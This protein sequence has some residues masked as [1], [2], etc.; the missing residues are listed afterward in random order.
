M[1]HYIFEKNRPAT[2]VY[3]I[4]SLIGDWVMFKDMVTGKIKF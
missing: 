2:F 4:Y 3:P 1:G